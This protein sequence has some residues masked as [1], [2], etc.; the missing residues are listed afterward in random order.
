MSS[1]SPTRPVAAASN[2]DVPLTSNRGLGAPGLIEAL[3]Q[4]WTDV[5]ENTFDRELAMVG[6]LGDAEVT[7]PSVRF[8]P[9]A[10]RNLVRRLRDHA[11]GL[12]SHVF[13]GVTDVDASSAGRQVAC[14]LH[15]V[16]ARPRGDHVGDGRS[17][18]SRSGSIAG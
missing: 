14:H 10:P 17:R 13:A 12:P 5:D 2:Q 6:Q 16:T 3:E 1:R 15:G 18:G 9:A 11:Q 4:R 7:A 8:P